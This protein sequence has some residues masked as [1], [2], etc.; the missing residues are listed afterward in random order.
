MNDAVRQF[1]SRIADLADA[2]HAMEQLEIEPIHLFAPGIYVRV[3]N[4]PAGSCIVSKI[5]KSE[6]FCLALKG[7]AT[8]VIGE[9]REE[10]KA[11][12]VMR[13]LPGT[14]R[15]LYIHEDAT[16]ITFHPTEKTDVEAIERDLIAESFDDPEL[17]GNEH[18]KQIGDVP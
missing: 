8:V 6:H 16:W 4:M 13:T 1:D 18:L 2:M 17:P 15:A 3:L 14:Q 12:K 10:I 7:R 5:H 11:P 9:E